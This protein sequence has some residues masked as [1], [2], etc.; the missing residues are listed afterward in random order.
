MNKNV[1][2]WGLV[3]GAMLLIVMCRSGLSPPSDVT[4]EQLHVIDTQLDTL[5]EG[6]VAMRSPGGWLVLAF[7][8][9]ILV[10]VVLSV[11][12]LWQ[13]DHSALHSDE[14]IQQVARHGLDRK[15]LNSNRLLKPPSPS[16][17]RRLPWRPRQRAHRQHARKET[18]NPSA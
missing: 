8:A 11:L 15:V 16:V 13:A 18:E 10:P 1:L 3:L 9:S 17:V 6:I 4:A 14:I 12:V 7:A 5:H 2:R